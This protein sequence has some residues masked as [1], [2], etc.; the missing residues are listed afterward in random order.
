MGAIRGDSELLCSGDPEDFAEL[1]RRTVAAVQAYVRRRVANPELA[2]DLI[3][4]TFARA[5]EGRESYDPER[6]LVVAWLFGIA[7]HL[8]IDAARQ[9]RVAADAR[10]RLAMPAIALDDADGLQPGGALWAPTPRRLRG[11]SIRREV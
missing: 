8:I 6:G 5:L 2:F 4:E 7:R 9:R 3:A 10:R 1:Y 11:F